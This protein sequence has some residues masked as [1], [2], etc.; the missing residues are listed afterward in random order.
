M[1]YIIYALAEV[2]TYFSPLDGGLNSRACLR[3]LNSRACLRILIS[4]ADGGLIS[5]AYLR[6]LPDLSFGAISHIESGMTHID[7]FIRYIRNYANQ[8]L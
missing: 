6:T 2:F 8:A 3:I 5:R 7:A 1:T 4:R